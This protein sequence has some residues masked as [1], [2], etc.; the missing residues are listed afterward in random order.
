M[1]KRKNN[2]KELYND[3]DYI[4]KKC[5]DAKKELKE[6]K[7]RWAAQTI[8]HL[9]LWFSCLNQTAMDIFKEG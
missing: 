1:K 5:N 2:S 8:Q 9:Q 6:G 3:L 4:I 7:P